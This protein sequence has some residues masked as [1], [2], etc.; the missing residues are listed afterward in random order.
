MAELINYERELKGPD[1]YE[2]FNTISKVCQSRH[3]NLIRIQIYLLSIIALIS[4]VPELK[5]PCELTKLIILLALIII[6]LSLMTIQ[7]RQ[8]YMEG[9]QKA[10]FLAESILSECWLLVFKYGDYSANGYDKSITLFHSRIKDM[11]NEVD[12]K[13]FLCVSEAPHVDHDNT[14]WMRTQYNADINQKRDFYVKHRVDDQIGW[15]EKK[16]MY[17][18]NKSNTFFVLGLLCMVMG[19]ILTIF[20]IGKLIPNLSYLGLFTTIAASIFSWKQ[21][22]RF[23]ELKTTYSVAA[24]ELTDFKKL[25]INN[26]SDG[27][28][29]Q[30]IFNTEKAISREHKIWYNRRA[31]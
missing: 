22:K 31:E 16:S 1:S 4:T 15:Y 18:T 23:E 21:T 26:G 6:V 12:I 29:K 19:M 27:E 11:K 25:I 20:V 5:E 17:N 24:D 7:F 28:L 2:H 10:R 9:W 30:L 14:N 13:E 3:L 8:N